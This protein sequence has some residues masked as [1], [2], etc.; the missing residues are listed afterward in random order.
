GY[1]W[2]PRLQHVPYGLVQVGGKKTATRL[3]NVV[4][5]REVFAIAE[6]EVRAK[7]A[8]VNPTLA[9]GVVG[10]VTREV[11]IGAVVFA[12]L[13]MQR[14]K[15]IDFELDKAVSLEGD[16]GPYLQM[17]HARCA[18]VFR[19]A[20]EDVTSSE[21]IDFGKL[22]HDAEWAVARRLLDFAEIV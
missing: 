12:N 16:S 22:G 14:E 20:G 7:I 3:G 11:G 6:E 2:A 5:M 9:P 1:D 8:E 13:V 4:L 15:N 10:K 21:G 19:K 17:Q 18:S